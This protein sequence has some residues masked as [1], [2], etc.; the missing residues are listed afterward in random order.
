[1]AKRPVSVL[2]PVDLDAYVRS[3][4][5]RTEWLREAIAEKW[6]RE[7]ERSDGE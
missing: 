7:I 5:D 2:L 3:R 6:E 4:P 1:M